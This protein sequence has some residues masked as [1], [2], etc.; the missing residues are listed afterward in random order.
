MI[1]VH[2][3]QASI[4]LLAPLFVSEELTLARYETT[5]IQWDGVNSVPSQSVWSG[6]GSV[7]TVSCRA[8]VGT[9]SLAGD[10]ELDVMTMYLTAN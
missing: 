7:V 9:Q 3:T 8:P 1:C 4:N 2:A 6:M 5:G 10:V